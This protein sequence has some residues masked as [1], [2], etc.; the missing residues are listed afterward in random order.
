MST[1]N[2]RPAL[3]GKSRPG[4]NKN[5]NSIIAVKLD[6]KKIL[7]TFQEVAH[8]L[9]DYDIASPPLL[10][11]IK[12]NNNF[13]DVVIVTTKIGNTLIFDRLNG[14]SLH[15]INYSK[16]PKSDYFEEIVSPMQI[17][18]ESPEPFMKLNLSIEDLDNRSTKDKEKI[19]NTIDD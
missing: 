19:I 13:F 16:V 7:W 14:T 2:P 15:D 1:G 10:A 11:K 3:I 12:I 9:W 6:E 4:K 8:D 5:A 18:T 17:K